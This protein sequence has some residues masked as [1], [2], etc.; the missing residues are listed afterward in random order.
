MDKVSDWLCGRRALDEKTVWGTGSHRDELR[1]RLMHSEQLQDSG[2]MLSHLSLFLKRNAFR[3]L[4]NLRAWVGIQHCERPV[5]YPHPH[6]LFPEANYNSS[7]PSSC[8]SFQRFAYTKIC[9][10]KYI[11]VY[12]V[13]VKHFYTSANRPS[14][15]S[16]ILIF[17]HFTY[18]RTCT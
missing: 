10:H 18:L 2:S 12:L 1:T 17:F 15:L 16:Y 9:I 3:W 8:L 6:F 13:C 7:L 14:S 11:C 5:S 4:K